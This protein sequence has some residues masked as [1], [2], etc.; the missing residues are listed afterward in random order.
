[1]TAA[2]SYY[3][4]LGTISKATLIGSS[5]NN[6]ESF[7]VQSDQLNPGLRW[8]PPHRAGTMRP[9][10]NSIAVMNNLSVRPIGYYKMAWSWEAFTQ[11]QFDYFLSTFFSAGGVWSAAVTLQ[12]ADSDNSGGYSA[13]QATM[14]RPVPDTDYIIK[15]MMLT[16]IT[17]KFVGGVLI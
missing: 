8:Q 7:P 13:Y 9:Q 6:I 3:L 4:A 14:L 17:F 16:K 11:N 5:S 1:M 12:T 2:Y 10:P 15:D